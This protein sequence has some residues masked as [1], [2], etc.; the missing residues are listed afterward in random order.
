MSRLLREHFSEE[1][2]DLYSDENY[3]IAER[4]YIREVLEGR[5][6]S[7]LFNILFPESSAKNF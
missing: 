2:K 6:K 4:R 7:P 3:K 5:I 1:N